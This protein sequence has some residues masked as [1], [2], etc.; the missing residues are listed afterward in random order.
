MCRPSCCN[1]TSHEGAGIAAV[2]IVIGAALIAIKLGPTVARIAHIAVEA[3]TIITLTV[4][5]AL[6]CLL[7]GWLTVRIVRWQNRRHHLQRPVTPQANLFTAR[8]HSTRIDRNPD[9]LACGGTGTVLR[10]IGSRY[11]ARPCPAC[12]PVRRAG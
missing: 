3:L 4:A 12:E 8:Q 11:Q 10:A 1:N 6:A 7:A 5:A 2:A 9:C